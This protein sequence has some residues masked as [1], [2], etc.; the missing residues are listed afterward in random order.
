[1]QPGD[2][3]GVVRHYRAEFQADAARELRFFAIQRSFEDAISKA[4]MAQRPDGKRFS[5]QRR[6][7]KSA[8]EESRRRL[9]RARS[10][11]ANA[12]DFDTLL[13]IIEDTIGPIHRIGKLTVYDTALRIAAWRR[14]EP[15]VIYLHAGTRVGA[16]ALGLAYREGVI[17]LKELPAPLRRLSAREIEDV[18]C[19]YKDVFQRGRRASSP[20]RCS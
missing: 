18:L 10:R 2:L 11:L 17:A 15:E 14:L 1:L 9:L 12:T 16:R 13:K 20:V 19:I 5:H 4:A 7:P 3:P 8:L 6:I